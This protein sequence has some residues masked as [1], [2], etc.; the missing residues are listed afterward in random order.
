MK[1]AL[2][3]FTLIFFSRTL[4]AQTPTITSFSPL[5]AKPGDVVTITG[6]NFNTTVANNVVFF[7]ATKATVTGASASS[8]TV[9]V[10]S[11]ATYAPVTVLNTG[12]SLAAQSSSKFTPV[13]SP[14]LSAINTTTFKPRVDSYNNNYSF[15]QGYRDSANSFV[16]VTLL[17]VGSQAEGSSITFADIDGDGKLDVVNT[18]Y[19]HGIFDYAAVVVHRNTSTLGAI[20][21]ASGILFESL[22]YSYDTPEDVVVGD[23]DGDGK[24]DSASNTI[25]VFKNTST[26]GAISMNNEILFS[27]GSTPKAI[28]M[29]DIDGD[30]KLDIVATNTGSNTVSVLRNT[31][32]SGTISFAAVSNFIVSS[33]PDDL[34]FGDIDGDGKQDLAITSVSSNSLSLLRNISSGGSISFDT[35]QDFATGTNPQAVAMGDI[36][37]DGKADIVVPNSGT[38]NISVFKNSSTSGTFSLLN[39]VDFAGGANPI[40]IQI[41]DLDNNGKPDLLEANAGNISFS[42]LQNA[43]YPPTI[44]SFTPT[45][46]KPGDVVTITGTNFNTTQVNNIVFFGATRATVTAATA[47]N[48]SVVVPVGATYDYVTVLNTDLKLTAQSASKF[49]PIFSPDKAGIITMAAKVDFTATSNPDN[50]SVASGDI[51]GDGKVDVIFLNKSANSVSIYRNTALNGSISSGSFASK[52]DFGTGTNPNAL[53]IGDIDGDGKLDLIISNTPS[54]I[55][56]LRNTSTN[57]N[58]SFASRIDFNRGGFSNSIVISDLD[59]DG[60]LDIISADIND[61]FVAV[62]TNSSS[63]GNISFSPVAKFF[64]SNNLVSVNVSDLNGD[65]KLD[66]VVLAD[67]RF[68]VFRNTSEI[69]TLSFAAETS[70]NSGINFSTS[71]ELGDID[72]DQ[73]PDL[74]IANSNSSSTSTSSL[75]VLRNTST[76]GSISFAPKA[77]IFNGLQQTSIALA[78]IDG[79][80]KIDIITV[81]AQDFVKVFPNISSTG[82]ISFG[83]QAN[84]ITDNSAR[85]IAIS[86][87]DG[88]SKPDL[89]VT[90]NNS[91]SLSVFRNA[92]VPPTITNVTSTKTNGSYLPGEQIP[93]TIT[94]NEAVNVTGTPQLTLETGATDRIINYTSGTGTNTLTFNY[95]VQTGDVSADL[96]YKL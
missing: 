27:V 39:K 73:K 79:N 9:T 41:A 69:G 5:S 93:I 11:G 85:S 6:T 38:N 46:A 77:D 19:T 7:G 16:Y 23:L 15:P 26:V 30:N 33:G 31:G 84:F 17:D 47:T 18:Y 3:F 24:P 14:A 76:S 22:N 59:S 36:D 65:S 49:S 90:N 50:K 88:D 32:S 56:V 74:I 60:R 67:N 42:V 83:T 72:G 86:D 55:S 62:L 95:I 8:L 51:D 70:I 13:F 92:D 82:N 71:M 45:S 54:N 96:D 44:T 34:F 48:L 43:D 37:G 10:P 80:Q 63:I 53:A 28:A 25:G 52:V 20:S 78:D 91:G 58:I 68:S 35:K 21:F 81:N 1:K 89:I 2:L 40:S 75:S 64:T 61:D 87:I 57:G 66:L 29:G 94:F 12:T 4:L